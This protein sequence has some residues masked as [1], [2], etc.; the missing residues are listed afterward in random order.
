LFVNSRTTNKAGWIQKP[1]NLWTIIS[2]T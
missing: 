2:L 1:G